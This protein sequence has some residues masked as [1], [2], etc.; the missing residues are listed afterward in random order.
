MR[1][2][3]PNQIT[4]NDTAIVGVFSLSQCVEIPSDRIHMIVRTE[5]KKLSE[6]VMQIVKSIPA[7]EFPVFTRKLKS[8]FSRAVNYGRKVIPLKLQ[9]M[10]LKM[11]FENI[12]SSY[13][14]DIF[15][16]NLFN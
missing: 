4:H 11:L 1:V 14:N 9:T 13:F 6:N 7:R 2:A 10:Q 15:R 16:Y 12:R 5:P 3:P 8:I